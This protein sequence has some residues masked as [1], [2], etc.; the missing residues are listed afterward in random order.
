MAHPWMHHHW[1]VYALF[2]S[3]AVIVTSNTRHWP[4]MFAADK[5]GSPAN[6]VAAGTSALLLRKA[7]LS[8]AVSLMRLIISPFQASRARRRP[9]NCQR[10]SVG[11]KLR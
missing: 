6:A 7:R 5:P 9:L 11:K 1:E 4:G 3:H 10:A 8:I 2:N